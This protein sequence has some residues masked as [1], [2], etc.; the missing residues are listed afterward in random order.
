MFCCVVLQSICIPMF[1]GIFS[2]LQALST[3]SQAAPFFVLHHLD[4]STFTAQNIGLKW[5]LPHHHQTSLRDMACFQRA[6]DVVPHP[7]GGFQVASAIWRWEKGA[8]F[9]EERLKELEI[10]EVSAFLLPEFHDLSCS[11]Q[12]GNKGTVSDKWF[13]MMN[14]TTSSCLLQKNNVTIESVNLPSCTTAVVP[15]WF[16]LLSHN[17]GRVD[18][19]CLQM[20]VPNSLEV[21]TDSICPCLWE[22]AGTRNQGLGMDNMDTCR[23]VSVSHHL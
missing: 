23:S 10:G 14:E 2:N 19:K 13:T 5:F 7:G 11:R 3:G 1:W 20:I 17:G 12:I 9:S 15:D 8:L 6:A 16:R 21:S 22:V 18:P 4:N